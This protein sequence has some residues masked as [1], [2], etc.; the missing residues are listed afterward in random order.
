MSGYNKVIHK[1]TFMT[2]KCQNLKDSSAKAKVKVDVI[3]S[4]NEPGL[5]AAIG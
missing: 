2:L 5:I 3:L 1:V 4:H